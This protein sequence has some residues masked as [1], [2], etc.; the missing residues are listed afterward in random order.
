MIRSVRS[1]AAV[2]AGV[3]ITLSL[4]FAVEPPKANTLTR[5]CDKFGSTPVSGGR[6]IVQNNEWGN[7]IPQCIDVTDNGFSIT[8]GYHNL[9][10]N[11]APA[12]YPSIYAGCHYGKCSTRSGLPLPVTAFDDVQTSASY[13][14]V[15]NG[16]WDAAYDIWFDSSPNPSGQNNGAEIMIWGHH[17]GPPKLFDSKNGTADLAGA[18]WDVWEGRITNGD[19]AWNLISYVR[20][21]TTNSLDIDVKEFTNDAAN[22]GY[23]QRS[24]YLTSVQFGFEPWQGGPGLTVN[25]FNFT[26][27]GTSGG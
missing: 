21:Q 19:T 12:A 3:L 1:R 2:V 7:S 13:S 20:Q 17:G 9:P 22:R 18:T 14:T 5:I 27:S 25:S 6:Y 23:V 10:T 8:S 16:R 24:W 26:T 15:N 11:G 4:F